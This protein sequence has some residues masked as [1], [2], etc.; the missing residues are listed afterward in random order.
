[1]NYWTCRNHVFTWAAVGFLNVL[2]IWLNNEELEWNIF[3]HISITFFFIIPPVFAPAG[4]PA[5][6]WPQGVWAEDG[7]QVSDAPRRRGTLV[8]LRSGEGDGLP[9]TPLLGPCQR[10]GPVTSA[11]SFKVGHFMVYM[12]EQGVSHP[13]QPLRISSPYSVDK[14]FH[15]K[16]QQTKFCNVPVNP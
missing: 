12:S 5:V 15:S 11:Q 7:L 14:I 2:Q 8:T 10:T 9:L 1:M 16:N 4:L 3:K 13:G 6:V